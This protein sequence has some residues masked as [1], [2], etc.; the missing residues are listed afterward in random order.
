MIRLPAYEFL[1]STLLR[2]SRQ[3]S[4]NGRLRLRYFVELRHLLPVLLIADLGLNFR[5]AR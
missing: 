5:Q 2:R 4:A 3:T 1:G